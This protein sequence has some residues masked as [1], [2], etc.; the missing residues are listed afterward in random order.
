MELSEAEVAEL[1]ARSEELEALFANFGAKITAFD[2][3]VN[4][5]IEEPGQPCKHRLLC[6]DM[7]T[8]LYS[9][10]KS[11]YCHGCTVLDNGVAKVKKGRQTHFSLSGPELSF[12]EP[13]LK[14]LVLW[15]VV[16]YD[17]ER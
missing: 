12:F 5:F 13:L 2:P 17:K 6:I 7:E 3:G 11:D 14:E 9:D 10:E 16:H 1:I 15:R 4:F 8:K